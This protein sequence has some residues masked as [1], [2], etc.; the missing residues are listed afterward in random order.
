LKPIAGISSV[1]YVNCEKL[2]EVINELFSGLNPGDFADPEEY[3]LSQNFRALPIGVSLWAYVFLTP[4]G[5]V[6]STG[7]EPGEL[8]RSRDN[9]DLLNAL[10]WGTE[11]YP[12]LA[13]L[14]PERPKDSS[15]CPLCN[16]AGEYEVGR[17][18]K[19]TA[20]CVCCGGLGWVVQ[21]D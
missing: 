12:S 4:D 5:E 14:I 20:I 18:S 19:Q 16:G 15:E 13:T 3:C 21:E 6:I 17:H 11:R 7:V 9:Q 8:K 2:K 10:V 1:K